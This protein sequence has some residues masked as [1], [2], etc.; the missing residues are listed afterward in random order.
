MALRHAIESTLLVMGEASGYDLSKEF[1]GARATFWVA[2]PQQLYREL[3][4]MEADGVIVAR[5]VEQE[6]R[7]NK[8]VF[9][10]T[11]DGCAELSAFTRTA[12]RAVAIRDELMVMVQ[13]VEVG[14][15]AAVCDAVRAFR[16]AASAKL[17]YYERL[18]RTWLGERRREELLADRHLGGPYLTLLRGLSFERE[19]IDWA[20][21]ALPVLEARG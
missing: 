9:R 15:P 19:N 17:A 6:K 5:T 3:D 13:A 20:E 2:T 11:D 16:D 7:P 12:P 10:L 4:R 21:L 18:E 14:D 8:R 1:D